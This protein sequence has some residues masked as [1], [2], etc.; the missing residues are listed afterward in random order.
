MQAVGRQA[1][2]LTSRQ[3]DCL[4]WVQEGKTAWEIGQILGISGRTVE[5]YLAIAFER[6]E[7]NTRVQAVLKARALGLL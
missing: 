7:V 6:L 3:I 1:L 5:S 2:P 4:R